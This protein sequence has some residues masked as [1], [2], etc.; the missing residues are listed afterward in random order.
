MKDTQV[1]NSIAGK[2]E[3]LPTLPGIAIK[4]LQAVQKEEPNISEIGEI[5]SKD[6]ALTAKILK[7]VNSSF[8]SL[9]SRITTVDHRFSQALL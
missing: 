9:S 2:I 4:L 5:L 6:V 3:N 8:Y 1:I 7:L